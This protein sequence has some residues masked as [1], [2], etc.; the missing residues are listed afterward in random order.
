MERA[1]SLLPHSKGLNVHMAEK[2]ALCVTKMFVLYLT[3]Q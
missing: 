1:C 3:E 2:E